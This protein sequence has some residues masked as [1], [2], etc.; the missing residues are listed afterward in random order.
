MCVCVC[1][2]ARLLPYQS[3]KHRIDL[4]KDV[5]SN[6]LGYE[7]EGVR[8][9]E[10]AVGGGLSLSLRALK[11]TSICQ[12]FLGSDETGRWVGGVRSRQVARTCTHAHARRGGARGGERISDH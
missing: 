3:A 8:E 6:V 11:K 10:G 12:D 7:E 1:A 4:P 5:A 2:C 9:G